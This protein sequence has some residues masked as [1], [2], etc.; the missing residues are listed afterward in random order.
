MIL[1]SDVDFQM[2][3]TKLFLKNNDDVF[4]QREREKMLNFYA[5]SIQ[6]NLR[7]Y[8]KRKN[9]LAMCKSALI[10]QTYWRS[11]IQ[12][13][14]YQQILTGIQRLQAILRSQQLVASYALLQKQICQFQA[15]R[16]EFQ[17][18]CIILF[19]RAVVARCCVYVSAII[20]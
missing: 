1:G 9:F 11:Y 3:K 20:I 18:I 17:L 13:R 8:A 19:R 10:I 4:L 5:T 14:K 2:G 6:K 7:R 12:R 15:S 16:L